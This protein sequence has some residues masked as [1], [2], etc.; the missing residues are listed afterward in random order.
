MDPIY[1][2][3]IVV[4][5]QY[6]VA[7][8]SLIKMFRCRWD[9]TPT[10]IWNFIIVFLPFLGAAAFWIYYLIRREKIEEKRLKKEQEQIAAAR[11]RAEELAAEQEVSDTENDRE[12]PQNEDKEN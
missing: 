8:L 7:V 12:E 1:V 10:I 2:A 5:C 3:V 4:L 9:K 6:P 11:K